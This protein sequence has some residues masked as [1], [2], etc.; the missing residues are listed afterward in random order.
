MYYNTCAQLANKGLP[1]KTIPND[2]YYGLK[3]CWE[4]NLG[5]V[6]IE[7]CYLHFKCKH[8]IYYFAISYTVLINFI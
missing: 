3:T 2:R 1:V 4:S 7:H 6:S 8:L 5:N